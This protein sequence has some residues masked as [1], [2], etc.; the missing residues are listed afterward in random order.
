MRHSP[1]VTRI[2]APVLLL[3]LIASP[4]ANAQFTLNRIGP[5]GAQVAGVGI[6][7]GVLIGV[8]IYLIARHP[9]VTGCTAPASGG[10]SLLTKGRAPRLYLL[11]G[12]T[13]GLTPGERIKVSGKRRKDHAGNDTFEVESLKKVL[14]P[15]AVAPATS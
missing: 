15:C 4:S 6:A 14:G 11:T 3:L 13:A 1:R 5:S 9:R 12:R 10:L 2:L 8:G 7:V